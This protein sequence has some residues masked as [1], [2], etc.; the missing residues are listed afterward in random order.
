MVVEGKAGAA[1]RDRYAEALVVVVVVLALTLGWV[2]KVWAEGRAV[3]IEVEGFQ[4]SYKH[5]WIREEPTPP[6][7]LKVVD[8]RSGGRFPT[9]IIVSRLENTGSCE[10]VAG[11]LNRTR[12]DDK[13]LYQFL[14]GESVQWRGENAYR[15]YFTYVHVSPDIINPQLPVVVHGMDHIFKS[16]STTFVITCV[17]DEN[18]YDEAMVACDRFIESVRTK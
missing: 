7:I 5:N 10:D 13:S 1:P 14:K 9:T 4:A 16:G 18:V 17:A 3:R 6:E 8:P 12:L 11:S 2:V 15:N